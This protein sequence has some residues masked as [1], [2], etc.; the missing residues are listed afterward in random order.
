MRAEREARDDATRAAWPAAWAWVFP[1]TYALHILEEWWG[2]FNVWAARLTG[3]EATPG[4]FLLWNGVAL[5]SMSASIVLTLRFKSFGWLLLA[6]GTAFL[7]NALSHLIASLYT[8]S[9]SPGLVTGLLFW[10]PLGALVLLRFR[11]RL[12]RRARRAGLLVGLLIHCV[13]L[14]VTLHGGR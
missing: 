12:T 8:T 11:K 4:E 13:V 6:Y 9:Y 5:L 2:G 7:L 1:A 14:L 3:V 10:L